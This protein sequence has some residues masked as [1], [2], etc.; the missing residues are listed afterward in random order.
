MRIVFKNLVRPKKAAVLISR[1]SGHKLSLCQREIARATGY[2]DWHELECMSQETQTRHDYNL[3][4]SVF[5]NDEHVNVISSI[6]DK[7]GTKAGDIQ[8]AVSTARLLGVEKRNQND[9][10][11]VRRKLFEKYEL[12]SV[13]KGE[14]GAIGK[15]KVAGRNGEIVILKEHGSPVKVI[16]NK[17]ADA[18]VADFEFV[19]RCRFWGCLYRCLCHSILLETSFLQLGRR[20]FNEMR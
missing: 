17:T 7:L 15:L 18:I 12:P 5:S 14:R 6:C 19:F 8:F 4:A 2:R 13:R 10:L 3:G 11:E 9:I 16:T 20:H 1:S